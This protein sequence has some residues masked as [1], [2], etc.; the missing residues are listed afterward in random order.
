MQLDAVGAAFGAQVGSQVFGGQQ[1]G[2]DAR[3]GAQDVQRPAD[4]ACRFQGGYDFGA[5]GGQ[6]QFG[7]AGGDGLVQRLDLLGAFGVRQ[8]N[9][10]GRAGHDAP[11][12]VD[13]K[14][15]V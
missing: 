2:A 5:S 8:E 9:G 3:A 1:A 15:V 4:A 13:R 11:Q 14:S 10:V 12:V 7:F 6:A